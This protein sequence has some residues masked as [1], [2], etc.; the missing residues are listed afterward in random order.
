MI[1]PKFNITFNCNDGVRDL[2]KILTVL[3][4]MEASRIGATALNDMFASVGMAG[5][6]CVTEV[7]QNERD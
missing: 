7:P 6:V 3:I 1:A 5:K 4:S 2:A